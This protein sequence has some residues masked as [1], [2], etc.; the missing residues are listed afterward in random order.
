MSLKDNCRDFGPYPEVFDIDALPCMDVKIPD[1]PDLKVVAPCDYEVLIVLDTFRGISPEAVHY[2]GQIKAPQPY[3]TDGRGSIGGYISAGWS[4]M[5]RDITRMIGG[6]YK[7][8][9]IRELTQD[10]IDKDPVRWE[11]YEAGCTTNGFENFEQLLALAVGIA[12]SRFPG[13]RVRIED[14]TK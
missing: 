13:W 1:R 12:K 2:Y 5:P 9:I 3:I 7:I 10:E 14:R 4:A 6:D 8:E 11:G